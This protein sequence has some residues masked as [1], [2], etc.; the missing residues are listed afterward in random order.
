[1]ETEI[2][3]LRVPS[4]TQRLTTIASDP[5]L[6][7]GLINAFF[8]KHLLTPTLVGLKGT[9][10]GTYFFSRL[11]TSCLQIGTYDLCG[12]TPMTSP[13]SGHTT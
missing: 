9:S 4:R 1:V 8:P 5:Q 6:G 3:L 10:E 2:L 11:Y 12:S 13:L 7:A